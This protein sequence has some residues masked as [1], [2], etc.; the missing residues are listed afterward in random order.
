MRRR[1]IEQLRLA[2]ARL[3]EQMKANGDDINDHIEHLYPD[4]RVWFDARQ[5]KLGMSAIN[6]HWEQIIPENVQ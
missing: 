1:A 5:D 6:V 3:D 4:Q 2:E